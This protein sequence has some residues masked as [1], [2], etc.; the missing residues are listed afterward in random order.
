MK[1]WLVKSK[2]EPLDLEKFPEIN[3]V[4]LQLLKDRGV[5]S[6]EQIDEFL[7][8]DYSQD[9]HD[10]Y[11]FRQMPQA[12]ERLYQARAAREKIAIYG[13]Y[14]A[15]GVCGSAILARVFKTLGLAF[16]VYIPHRETEGYGLNSQAI[17]QLAAQKV[18]L[19]I[20]VDCGISNVAEVQLAKELGLDVIITDHHHLPAKLPEALAIIHP[21]LDDHY[22]FKSLAG[23]GV[24]FKLA[25]AIISDQRFP[26]DAAIKESSEKWLLDLVAISTVADLM[27]LLG[28]NRTLVKYGLVVLA[29]TKNLG[30]QKLFEVATINPA[31][32]DAFT[33]GY[34][35][36]P[37]INAAGRMAHANSAYQLLVTENL[38]EAIT[39]AHQLNKR[40]SERQQLVDR[41]VEAAKSQLG[42]VSQ[43]QT[44][45]FASGADWP[46]GVIGLVAGKLVNL[47]FRPAIVLSEDKDKYVASGRSIEEFNLIEALAKNSHLLLRFGGHSGAAG[48]TMAKENLPKFQQA[49]VAQAVALGLADLQFAGKVMIDLEVTLKDIDWQLLEQISQFE[50]FGEDNP[51]PRF[52]IKNLQLEA[53]E[54]VG[55]DNKHV[56]LWVRQEN[57]QRKVIAFGFADKVG[58]LEAADLVDLVVT[59]G[60]NEWNGN[61]EIQLSLVDFRKSD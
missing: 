9:I 60:V 15:D 37:R 38:E 13:D 20:T 33:I 2:I 61:R 34:Q 8:P 39:I 36:A 14:D 24:A 19:I 31:K 57:L 48:F 7:H 49:L 3:P 52:L 4:I 21:L 45:L 23:G 32:I 16:Q 41:L 27:P 42:D 55:Q 50:P 12:V 1:Q 22:P 47:Y 43:E 40:N 17:K 10:P 53:I 29:K 54:P 44:I 58:E 46:A 25:Q 18:S 56:R 11:L 30:L 59:V 28:E 51:Q 26:G 35:I 5:S 6:Q